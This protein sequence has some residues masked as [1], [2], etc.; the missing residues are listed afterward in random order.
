MPNFY[1][2]DDFRPFDEILTPVQIPFTSIQLFKLIKTDTNK[3]YNLVLDIFLIMQA[4]LTKF[5]LL[6]KNKFYD[7]PQKIENAKSIG[8][9]MD[10]LKSFFCAQFFSKPKEKF[11]K[12]NLS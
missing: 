6:E 11:L 10:F 4:L 1:K 3:L 7:T 9:Y 8:T 2:I 12:E 5:F